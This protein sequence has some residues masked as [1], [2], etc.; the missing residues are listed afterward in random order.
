[1]DITFGRH[2]SMNH[3]EENT[4]EKVKENLETQFERLGI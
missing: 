4:G 2:Y 3:R 1:M